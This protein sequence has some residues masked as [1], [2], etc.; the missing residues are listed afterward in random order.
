MD[1][2]TGILQNLK[3]LTYIVCEASGAPEKGEAAWVNKYKKAVEEKDSLFF[4][5]IPQEDLQTGGR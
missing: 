4:G 5:K 1:S 3:D 2:G